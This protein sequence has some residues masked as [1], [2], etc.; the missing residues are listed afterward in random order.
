METRANH[1]LVGSFVLAIIVAAFS[2]II[3][4]AKLEVDREFSRYTIYFEGSVAG[5][6]TASSVLYN[7]IPVGTVESIQLDPKNPQRVQVVIEIAATTPVR[8]ETVAELQ[9]QGITGVSQVALSGG[10]AASPPLTQVLAGERYPVIDSRPSQFQR[11]FS[12]APELIARG[13]ELLEQ[14]T[15]LVNDQNVRSVGQILNDV[16]AVSGAVASR[17]TEVSDI[18]SNLRQTSKEMND[19]AASVSRLVS[20]LEGRV[21]TM[22]DSMEQTMAV[23]RGTMAG[24]DGVVDQDLRRVLDSVARVSSGLSG[25]VDETR[26]P[27]ADFS[28]DGLYELSALIGEMRDL[29]SSLSRLSG[30]IEAD[31]AQFLFGGRQGFEAKK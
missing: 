20:S 29:M 24:I 1:I 14:A 28:G 12:G 23:A 2:F 8:R 26:Q 5:L 9:L 21:G 30:R 10:N 17:S 13:I 11:L 22:A 4:L 15:K 6:T 19:A 7:G 27:V 3:W 25:L 31:P 18:V 16:N